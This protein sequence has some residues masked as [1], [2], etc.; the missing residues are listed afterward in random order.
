M[1]EL[2]EFEVRGD[3]VMWWDL[4]VPACLSATAC[5]SAVSGREQDTCRASGHINQSQHAA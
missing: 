1:L 5:I 2:A 3:S 4:C